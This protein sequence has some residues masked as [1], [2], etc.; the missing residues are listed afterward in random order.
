MLTRMARMQYETKTAEIT[1]LVTQP[2]MRLEALDLLRGLLMIL[3]AL[4][5]TRDYFSNVTINATAP[6][7]SWPALFITRWITHLCAPGFVALA[8]TSVYLQRRRGKSAERVSWLLFSRG[9]W[10]LL[11]D[12]SLITFGR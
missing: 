11:L 2:K 7:Q 4:D 6:L 10:L 3:M 8:G 12:L 1:A 5:H 9:A